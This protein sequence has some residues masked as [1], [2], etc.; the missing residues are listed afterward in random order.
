M[1]MKLE[2]DFLFWFSGKRNDDFFKQQNK[3]KRGFAYQR[4]SD[5]KEKNMVINLSLNEWEK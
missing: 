4:W 5:I 1:H 3:P 2:L